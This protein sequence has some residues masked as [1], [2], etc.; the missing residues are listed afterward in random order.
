M[1]NEVC[2]ECKSGDYTVESYEESTPSLTEQNSGI[3][4][5]WHCKCDN[6]QTHFTISYIYQLIGTAVSRG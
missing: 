4:H 6:C 1:W 5:V 3:E 2:P